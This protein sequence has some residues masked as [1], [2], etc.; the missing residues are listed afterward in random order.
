MNNSTNLHITSQHKSNKSLEVTQ[1]FLT[2][3]KLQIKNLR[4]SKLKLFNNIL[5]LSNKVK[6]IFPKQQTLADYNGI[7][8]QH[9]N[10]G[11][12][13][14]SEE[15]L[16]IKEYRHRKTCIYKPDSI[17]YNLDV[18]RYLASYLPALRFLPLF[19]F[20]GA[21]ASSKL[22]HQEKVTPNIRNIYIKQS[23]N[24]QRVI[25]TREQETVTVK[26]T[27]KS[28]NLTDLDYY[29]SKVYTHKGERVSEVTVATQVNPIP[30]YIRELSWL[31]LTKW[32]QIKLTPYCQESVEFAASQKDN[33]L[34][35][36]D[37]FKYFVSLCVNYCRDRQ[38]KP[39]W[40]ISDTLIEQ[41][42]LPDNVRF[43]MSER[44][45]LPKEK[46]FYKRERSTI[47]KQS[48]VPRDPKREWK[49]F[50]R[51]EIDNEKEREL[52]DQHVKKHGPVIIAGWTIPNPFEK[53]TEPEKPPQANLPLEYNE[54]YIEI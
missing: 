50:E 51:R 6:S 5:D 20:I 43:Y 11:L 14:L 47:N 25:L 31:C 7:T 38:I 53:R 13:E 17:F 21:A 34:L 8:R 19:V 28:K 54:D 23:L 36:N 42:P 22:L 27:V 12:G 4:P 24:R 35:A 45:Q 33:V 52:Y 49:G 39:D 15:K 9:A 44:L 1:D 29:K 48:T 10:K 30:E 46:D 3:L 40:H 41:Y 32:G 16:I 18:R 26:N 37:P 2:N